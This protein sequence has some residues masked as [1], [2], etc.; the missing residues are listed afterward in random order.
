MD[1]NEALLRSAALTGM[2]IATLPEA[3][4]E[5]DVANGNLI[6]VLPG[7]STSNSEVEV[8]LFYSHRE[9]LPARFRTFVD[10]C[11][12]FFR[13]ERLNRRPAANTA[14]HRRTEHTTSVL[15]AA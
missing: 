8:C 11:T 12:T 10:F 15:S 4:I 3:M 5:E 2:G 14:L 6:Q 7:C 1:G 13:A 9:L